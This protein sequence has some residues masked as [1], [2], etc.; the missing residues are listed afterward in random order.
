MIELLL[1][2]GASPDIQEEVKALILL[3]NMLVYM[4][5]VRWISSVCNTF[6]LTDFYLHQL[7]QSCLQGYK[8]YAL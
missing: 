8:I 7:I 5:E 3:G 2:A 1:A 6:F 4:F